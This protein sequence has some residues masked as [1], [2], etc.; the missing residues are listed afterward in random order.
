MVHVEYFLIFTLNWT[1]FNSPLLQSKSA[2]L[3]LVLL[4][5][6]GVIAVLPKKRVAQCQH[7]HL[8]VNWLVLFYMY[9]F[10]WLLAMPVYGSVVIIIASFFFQCQDCDHN[11]SYSLIVLNIISG[12]M[13]ARGILHNPSMFSG[14]S[15]TPLDCVEDWVRKKPTFCVCIWE[16]LQAS[17]ILINYYFT[18]SCHD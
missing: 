15:T 12:V 6:Y 16:S 17:S 1:Y 2:G 11:L 10:S 5:Y 9:S 4:V 14:Y 3:D 8:Q 7:S 13:V 18:N